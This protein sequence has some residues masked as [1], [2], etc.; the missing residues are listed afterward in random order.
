MSTSETLA[1]DLLRIGAVALRPDQPFTWASGRL[2]PVYTDNR[3]ALSHPAVRDRVVAGFVDLA[4]RVGSVEA[5]SGTATAGIA[6]G[7]L[8]ADRLGV[9]FSYV[10]AAAKGHGREN[11]I[12][13]RVEPGQRVV[14]VEDLVS[15]GGSVVSAAEALREAGGAVVGALAVFTYGFPEADRAF[16][17]AGLD[18]H[19]LTDFET[20]ARLAAET[21]ALGEGAWS[22]LRAWRDDP[23]GWSRERGGAG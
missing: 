20:L 12:E 19:T 1:R 3:L 22:V 15:T 23:A 4:G 13:G 17:D 5:V 11:R 6:P 7:A 2:A 16:D 8:L 9:P 10:R 21:G 14:V 18:L